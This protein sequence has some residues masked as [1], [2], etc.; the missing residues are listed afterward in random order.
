MIPYDFFRTDGRRLHK[1]N[2]MV[3]PRRMNHTVRASLHVSGGSVHHK[4]DT[5]NQ[6]DFDPRIILQ[7]NLRR[8][9][10]NKLRFRRHD[11]FSLCRLG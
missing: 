1:R 5:V 3:E 2:L 4:A 8:V 11:G 6:P 7:R 9:F 10:R